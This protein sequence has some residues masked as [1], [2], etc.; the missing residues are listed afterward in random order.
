MN[1]LPRATT[2]P[3]TGTPFRIRPPSR[4]HTSAPKHP[5]TGARVV[6]SPALYRPAAALL[7]GVT[8][9]TISGCSNIGLGDSGPSMPQFDILTP[10]DPDYEKQWNMDF[11]AMPEAWGV[12][13][14]DEVLIRLE[15]EDLPRDVIVAVLDTE[16]D[17][18]HEDLQGLLVDGYDAITGDTISVSE[19]GNE[20]TS[21]AAAPDPHGTHVAGI[22]GAG[23]DNGRGVAGVGWLPTGSTMRIMPVTVLDE[24]GNGSFPDIT[25]GL[26]YAA[27]LHPDVN[28]ARPAD[29]INMSLGGSNGTAPLEEALHEVLAAGI[30]VMAAAGN[31]SAE[32]L[33]YPAR[34]ASTIAVGSVNPPDSERA[35]YSNSGDEL[36]ITAP[37]GTGEAGDEEFDGV[38]SLF[39]EDGSTLYGDLAGTSMSAPHVSG[40]AALLYSLS[41]DIAPDSLRQ[42]LTETATPVDA[43]GTLPGAQY[44]WGVLNADRAVRRALM[45]PYGPYR[46]DGSATVHEPWPLEPRASVQG[47]T[48]FAQEEPP[49]PP[50]SYANDRVALVLEQEWFDRTPPESRQRR[51]DEIAQT[52]GAAEIRDRGHR[53]PTAELSSGVE[54]TRELLDAIEGADEIQSADFAVYFHVQ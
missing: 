7:L 29:I 31:D 30:P 27:G 54:A 17:V 20:H 6:R 14:S 40:V 13:H 39:P 42:I 26:L 47:E 16:I 45:K 41:R 8:L 23:S 51:L 12:I 36:D 33:L 19:S 46:N 32:S 43:A 34:Y 38:L 53:Y 52:H 50:E 21:S 3:P 9:L 24:S 18:G 37:G 35:Y 4:A 1:T 22:I 2:E 28:P 15:D 44:G 5:T 25:E 10:N 48:S 11:I 49:E